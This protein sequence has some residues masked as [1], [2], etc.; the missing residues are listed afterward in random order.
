MKPKR[1]PNLPQITSSAAPAADNHQGDD[2][3]KLHMVAAAA[4][5]PLV[6][7][8]GCS[9]AHGDPKNPKKN[10]HPVKRYEVTATVDPSLS[11][12]SVKGYVFFDVVNTECVPRGV[13]TGGQNVPNNGYEFEMT[14]LN[15]RTWKGYVYRDLLQDED[16]FGQGTCHWDMTGVTP[17]FTVHGREFSAG[18]GIEN[19]QQRDS[20][21]YFKKS[22]Y[23]NYSPGGDDAL[24]SAVDSPDVIQYPNAFFPITVTVREAMP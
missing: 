24:P 3:M 11:W 22:E 9:M 19:G 13:F 18:I 6:V 7:G 10:P 15:D 8:A 21:T 2:S 23:F 12:D 4:I 14:R 5:L 17:S 20:L 16:Y 1:K